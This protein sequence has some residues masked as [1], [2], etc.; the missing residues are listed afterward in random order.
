MVRDADRACA[1]VLRGS[2]I[3]MA[4]HVHDGRDYWTLPGG[5]VEAAETAAQAAIRELREET[6]L[7]GTAEYRL[8]QRSY[9]GRDGGQ[10]TE[11]CYLVDVPGPGE[12]AL[13][14][15]P[16]A[17]HGLAMLVGVSWVPV[18]GLR[19]DVQVRRILDAL[20]APISKP[21]WPLSGPGGSLTAGRRG[22]V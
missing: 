6:G 5:G 4:H 10:V 20:P 19:G 12:P 9:R 16:E 2:S 14:S 15:D 3:L 21:R 8:C 7:V 22:Y 13:G 18:A 11:H 17:G 1:A